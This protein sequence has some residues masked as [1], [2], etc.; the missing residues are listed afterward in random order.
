M[1]PNTAA[2]DNSVDAWRFALLESSLDCVIVMD[3]D[4][5]IVDMNRDVEATF[6][7]AREAIIGQRLAD[8][9]IPPDLREAHQRGFARYLATGQSTF[10]GT[11]VEV[12]ALDSSGRR[13][14][15][16]LSVVRLRGMRPALFVGRL[17]PIEAQKRRERRL[18]ASAAASRALA[19]GGDSNTVT[20]EVLKAIGQELGWP[21]VQYWVVS[22]DRRW[23]EVAHAWLSE[24]RS[25]LGSCCTVTSLKQG[26]GL[27]GSVWASGEAIWLEDVRTATH[28]PRFHELTDLGVRSA[29]CLP[30]HVRSQVMGAIEAFA[31]DEQERDPHLL[32]LLDAIAGQL[33]HFIEELAARK[34]LGISEARLRRALE[35]EREARAAA[36]EA[37]RAKDHLL[38]TV[39]HELRTPLGPILGWA[40]MLQSVRVAPEM[41]TRALE[42]IARNAELQARLVED[43]LDMSRMTAGKLTLSHEDVDLVQVVQAAIETFR[44][45]ADRKRLTL[46]FEGEVALPFLRGDPK[47]LQQVVANLLGNAVKFTPEDG[48]ITIGLRRRNDAAIIAVS[49]T[50]IG[51]DPAALTKVFEP[52]HQVPHDSSTQGLGLGLSIVREIVQAHAGTVEAFS[53]GT[54]T[55]ATF[56]VTL[57]LPQRN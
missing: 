51:L 15:V 25:D 45:A 41:Q 32:A 55:G 24:D 5:V 54:G 34:A 21:I 19:G 13:I 36:E 6:G 37:N 3:A 20:R 52:F 14:L 49:D 7:F 29:V 23:I 18:R 30:V 47:R 9:F 31:L 17:R 4:G 53:A 35:G 46:D 8:V 2:I 57:P 16:E 12:P 1:N 10:L 38:A 40:K 50:G 39:S 22:A 27:P 44:Q 43:L 42:A 28:L 26:E 11:R 33:G 56:V 48:R